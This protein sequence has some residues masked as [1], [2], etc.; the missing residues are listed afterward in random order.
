MNHTRHGETVLALYP[1]TRGLGFVVM[2]SP[3][4]ASGAGSARP[5][6]LE[7]LS[8]SSSLVAPTVQPAVRARVTT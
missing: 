6:T 2:R 5:R 7:Q 3:L 4:S 8:F 1:T